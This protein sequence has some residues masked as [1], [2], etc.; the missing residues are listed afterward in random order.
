[1]AVPFA[2][3]VDPGEKLELIVHLAGA[4]RENEGKQS[5]VG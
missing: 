4:S 1:M 3:L 2:M 5:V